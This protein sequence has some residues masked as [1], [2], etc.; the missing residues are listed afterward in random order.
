MCTCAAHAWPY[1]RA[2]AL[3]ESSHLAFFKAKAVRKL[4]ALSRGEM[5]FHLFFP[6]FSGIGARVSAHKCPEF[7]FSTECLFSSGLY[8]RC[9]DTLES[10]RDT[11]GGGG[12]SEVKQSKYLFLFWETNGRVYIFFFRRFLFFFRGF[13]K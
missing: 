7:R 10:Y 1:F 8:P 9:C 6:L 13:E 3:S 12:A 2:S 5:F 11:K 4:V